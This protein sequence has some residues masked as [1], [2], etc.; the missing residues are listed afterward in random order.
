[1]R[2]R[3]VATHQVRSLLFVG[4]PVRVLL[5]GQDRAGQPAAAQRDDGRGGRGGDAAPP[6]CPP[7]L[8]HLR[9]Q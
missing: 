5:G 7:S 1:V 4:W 2:G 9:Q 3:I 8:R 6:A